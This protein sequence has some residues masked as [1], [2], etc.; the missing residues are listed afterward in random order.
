MGYDLLFSL[1]SFFKLLLMLIIKR[2]LLIV[3]L[4][5][6]SLSYQAQK[7]I[8]QTDS[9]EFFSIKINLEEIIRFPNGGFK[10]VNRNATTD[11]TYSVSLKRSDNITCNVA[12]K[13]KNIKISPEELGY[14]VQTVMGSDTM[15]TF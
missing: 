6:L 1:P 12:E 5:I 8:I 10:S 13:A 14:S 2:F 3:A 7:K 11:N 15:Q 9:I 4:L